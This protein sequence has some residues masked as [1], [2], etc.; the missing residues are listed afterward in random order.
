LGMSAVKNREVRV[1]VDIEAAATRLRVVE[2]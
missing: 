1:T 2:A